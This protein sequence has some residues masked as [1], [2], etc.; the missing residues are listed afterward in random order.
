MSSESD[1]TALIAAVYEAGMDLSLWPYA[2]ERIAAAFGAPAAG[3]ARQGETLSE[4]WAF[5]SGM[6]PDYVKKY[7]DYYHS[8]N[9]IWQSVP[10]AP[11]GTV[12]TDTMV[13]PR[14]ELS[15]TEFF[16]DFL[17][18]QQMEGLLNAVVLLEEER[19][20]VVTVQGHRQFEASDVELYRL[21]TPHLQRAVQINIKLAKAELNHIASVETLNHLEEGVLFVDSNAK[22]MFANKAAEK[23]FADRDLR[24]NEGR[25]HASSA[26]ETATLHAVV[27]KCAETG[28]Q[29]RRSDFVSLRRKAGRSPL[30][31]LIAPLPMEIPVWPT[32]P[33]PMVVIFVNDPDRNGKPDAVQLQEKFGMTPAEARFAAEILKGDGIQAA[34]DRLSISRATART[35]LSRIFDKTGTRRQAELVG[36]LLSIKTSV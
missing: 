27:A 7:I 8:V 26:A 34:A 20:S 29:H 19:Q 33:R 11:V 15:R 12:Q 16:N 31:L 5:S 30:S 4:C 9:P 24:L 13:I 17:M 2:L 23:F 35:H 36:V 32:A 10:T 18:P 14:S 6:E 3:I 22:I 1:L 28:I 25:L 21:L